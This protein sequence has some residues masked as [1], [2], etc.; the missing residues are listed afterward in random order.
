MGFGRDG[1]WGGMDG[2][3]NVKTTIGLRDCVPESEGNAAMAEGQ[4]CWSWCVATLDCE[5]CGCHM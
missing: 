5:Y 2:C 3:F 4:G 1:G